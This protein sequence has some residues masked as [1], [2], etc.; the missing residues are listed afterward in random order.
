MKKILKYIS[1]LAG[2]AFLTAA[3]TQSDID[4]NASEEMGTLR[5]SVNIGGSRTDAYNALD[6]STM[7]VYKIE[8]GEEKLIRK[9]QPATEAPGD[10]YL[11]AGSYRIK[12]EAGDQ[13]QATFTNKSYYGELDVD[14]KPQQV[15]L[16]E[17]VCPI[18]NIGV[19]VVFDQTILDKMDPGFKAYVSAID[20]FSKTEA[21]NGS[22]PTLK[23]TE[24][25][26]GYYLLP[27]DVHNLSWGFYSSSTELGS[28]SK[29]GVIPTP[30]SGNLYTLTFKY[31]KTPNGYLGI[32]VQ[33]DED[34]EIHEDPFIFS[35]QPT[36][37][38]DGFDINSVIGFNTDD[39]S[40]AVSSVQA[41]SGI[42]VKANDETI[43]VLSD[44]ALLPE[45]AAKGISYIKTDDNSGKLSLGETFISSFAGG[46]HE[47]EFTMTDVAQ[48]EGTGKARIAT[49][50]LTDL[51]V[52][53][54][55]LNT[56]DFQVIV[57][58]PALTNVKVRY[59]ERERLAESP[60][61]GEWKT[62]A[63][64]AGADYT[65]T[66]QA[67]DFAA[68]R[69]YEYQLLIN[70]AET[71]EVHNFSTATGVQLPNAGFETWTNSKTWY[72][73]S[74]DE[75]GSNGMGT[76]YTGF[77]GTGNPGANAAGIVVTEPADDPRPGSTGTKSALLKTQSAFGVIAAGNLFIG[78]FGGVHH[79]TKGDVYMG[80]PFTF[81]ARPKAI[82][83]WYKGTVGSG[84][85]ARFFICMGKWSSYHK[86][87]TNDQSTFFDPK[88]ESL[89]EGPI[90]GYGDWLNETSVGDWTKIVIPITYR[91]DEMPNYLMVT[92]SASYRG[93][94]MEGNKE[95]RMYID[96]IEFV[97]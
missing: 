53:D 47:V 4:G 78:A 43:Q 37:K 65:Y 71:G 91:S 96:D 84:D 42:S 61:F 52:Y 46:I 56:A 44:G 85:K 83:F 73:C 75:I 69:D 31:S 6:R 12:V 13:S 89:P 8:N 40:F 54:L 94:Y 48:A 92:A 95:S 33:V 74:A 59:R 11:V 66:A 77:W 1:L 7:R 88:Q 29:T 58:D 17:V 26:T 34:G 87:D 72:P 23:Y 76:G 28:I 14:I 63:A 39:I 45:A 60:A 51:A 67:T 90:Y 10:L 30:E 15:I 62:V 82:T 21:E 80:R 18:T 24:D 38:G 27:E 5:L 2:V 22:V 57:T 68:D 49:P 55:W 97:Y 79:I 20:T 3:C 9:Y 64:V 81:N 16:K 70:D 50:G 41:L 19:K 86:I 36:I 35:P 32:T 25:A 93:D